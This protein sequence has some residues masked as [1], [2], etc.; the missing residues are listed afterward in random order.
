[1]FR[2]LLVDDSPVIRKMILKALKMVGL[3][4]GEALEAGNGVEALEIL[5][6]EWIDIVFADLNMPEMDGVELV[7]TMAADEMLAGVPVVV[8]S[9]LRSEERLERLHLAGISAYL[10]KPLQTVE[11]KRTIDDL[12][13]EHAA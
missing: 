8:I 2:I 10:S 6:S 5:R 11:L 9:S 3:P 13:A 4:V 12:L 7:E 1:M